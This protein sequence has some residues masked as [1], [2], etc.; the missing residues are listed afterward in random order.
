M[1]TFIYQVVSTA[2]GPSISTVPVYSGTVILKPQE[3]KTTKNKAV[4]YH[5]DTN[6]KSISCIPNLCDKEVQTDMTSTLVPVPVPLFVPV[7]L[8]MYQLPL[9]QPVPLPLPIP[10]PVFIP[11]TRKSAEGIFQEIQ[12]IREKIPNDPYEAELLM[13]AEAVASPKG[14]DVES[15]PSEDEGDPKK[16]SPDDKESSSSN[17]QP[18]SS[19]SAS[20]SPM[21]KKS[22]PELRKNVANHVPVKNSSDNGLHCADEDLADLEEEIKP[23]TVVQKLKNE[24]TGSYST[25]KIPG[26]RKRRRLRRG[27]LFTRSKRSRVS[28]DDSGE[29]SRGSG[30]VSDTDSRPS[31]KYT[32]GV[33]AWKQWVTKKNAELENASTGRRKLKLFKTDLL[34]LAADELN[35]ALCLFVKEVKRPNG[36]EYSPDSILYLC[37]GI[38][39]YLNKNGRIDNIFTDA[40]YEKFTECL[41]EVLK[42]FDSPAL[43][44]QLGAVGTRVEEEHLWESSQLGAHSPQ[45]LLYT[46]MYYNTKHFLLCTVSEHMRLAFPHIM[47]NWIKSNSEPKGSV[48]SKFTLRYYPPPAVKADMG[49]KGKK[50]LEQRENLENPLRCPV[51]LHEFY[52]SRCPESIRNKNELFYLYPERSCVPDSPVWYSRRP[53][54]EDAIA[55]ML[56]CILLVREIQEVLLKRD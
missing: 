27:S 40:F 2:S 34:R 31:L 23:Y 20:S 6:N 10:V 56:H 18:S 39:V 33:R 36:E 46:V 4:W 13:L 7:P 12:K 49:E 9:P 19:L 44:D 24:S 15:S 14:V 32:Y 26:K 30:D 38:Q 1:Q 42:R 11:T 35:Y 52:L 5:P 43:L 50:L 37:L 41:D 55:K 3:P 17:S 54:S 8:A 16:D 53:L 47:K 21:L 45:V 25:S 29:S 48:A 22:R 51:K 28:L